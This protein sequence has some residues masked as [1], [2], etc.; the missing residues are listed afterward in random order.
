MVIGLKGE[1]PQLQQ[2]NSSGGKTFFVDGKRKPEQD[3][4]LLDKGDGLLDAGQLTKCK[5][6]VCF[7]FCSKNDAEK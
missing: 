5:N 6:A 3:E 2:M 4:V 7:I 1:K